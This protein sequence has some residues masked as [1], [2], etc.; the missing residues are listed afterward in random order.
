MGEVNVS[1]EA[2]KILKCQEEHVPNTILRMKKDLIK[3]RLKL[4][5]VIKRAQKVVDFVDTMWPNDIGKE[6]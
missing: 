6:K 2:S 5:D 3:S 4:K 1:K